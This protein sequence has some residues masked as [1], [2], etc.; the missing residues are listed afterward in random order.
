MKSTFIAGYFVSFYFHFL[1]VATM[2]RLERLAEEAARPRLGVG[3]AGGGVAYDLLVGSIRMN[4]ES[5]RSEDG[6][7]RRILSR[8]DL[9][10]AVRRREPQVLAAIV[11]EYLSHI[12]RAARGAGLSP[13]DAED[14]T[15]ETFTTFLEVAPRFEGRS[16]VRTFLFGI[17]YKKI[18]KTRRGFQE[19]RYRDPID[20]V[21]E[22]RFRLDGS[23]SR[24]PAATD[25]LAHAGE[26][27]H[28]LAECLETSPAPQRMA[29]YL[30]EV[31]GLERSEILE[32]L[33]IS[34][35]NLDVMLHRLRNR[36]RE[37]LEAKSVGSPA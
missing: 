29:F 27:R 6:A 15:Q 33:D 31:E 32:A 4:A 18:A 2:S 30:R 26:T 36:T 34:S 5:H 20:E 10:E 21:M 12:L 19:A 22:S 25:A 14:V 3:A 16:L 13:Q 23:W 7:P 35:S 8:P 9:T 1:T 17:L 11:D 28:F 37:C 24:P